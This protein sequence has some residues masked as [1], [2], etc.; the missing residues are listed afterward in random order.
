MVLAGT[1]FALQYKCFIKGKARPL[2]TN[3]EFRF[4]LTIIAAASLLLTYFLFRMPGATVSASLRDSMFQVSSI[5][6]TTGFASADFALWTVPAQAVLFAMMLTGSCAGSAGGGVK[7]VR[8]LFVARFLIREIDQIVHP[9]AILPIK[10]D[11]VTIQDDIQRQMLSF[12][13]FYLV[14]LLFSGLAVTM[15]EQNAAVGFVGTA[16]TIGN[17]GPGFGE[18]GPMGSFG[19]LHMAS[20]IIFTVDMIVGRLELIPF[21]AML[22]P[23]FWSFARN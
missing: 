9:R 20:K 13:L 7:V 11:R 8:V 5:I 17:I 12:L 14:L 21:L 19:N 3:D 1:N 22:S 18:I 4:Y 10:I 16:A 6:T 15:I 2:V 23:E